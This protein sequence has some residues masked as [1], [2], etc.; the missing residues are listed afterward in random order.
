LEGVATRAGELPE[1]WCRDSHA[2]Y[3][4]SPLGWSQALHLVASVE[5]AGAGLGSHH[6]TQQL[7]EPASWS[8]RLPG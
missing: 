2:K 7:A 6:V 8:P 5:V 3:F 4:N 1:S